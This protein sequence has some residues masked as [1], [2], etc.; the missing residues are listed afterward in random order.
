MKLT[1]LGMLVVLI[2]VALLCRFLASASRNRG[3]L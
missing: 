2:T 3:E 1:A